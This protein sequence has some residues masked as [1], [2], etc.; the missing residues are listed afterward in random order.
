MNAAV[1]ALA[2]IFTLGPHGA[3]SSTRFVR[4]MLAMRGHALPTI[5]AYFDVVRQERQRLISRSNG[6]R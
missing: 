6:L 3:G 1:N 5:S 2:Q 4:N